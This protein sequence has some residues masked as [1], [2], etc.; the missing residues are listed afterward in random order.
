MSDDKGNWTTTALGSGEL[1]GK[2]P[3]LRAWF[4]RIY[5]ALV[6]VGVWWWV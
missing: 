5:L 6:V 2:N 1:S 4:W 3:R